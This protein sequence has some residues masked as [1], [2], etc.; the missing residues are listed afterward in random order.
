MF[1]IDDIEQTFKDPFKRQNL[2]NVRTL[3]NKRL[4]QRNGLYESN[5]SIRKMGCSLVKNEPR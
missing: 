5:V 3:V 1:V 4:N 2:L